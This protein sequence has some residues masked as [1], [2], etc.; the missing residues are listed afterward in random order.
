VA[1]TPPYAPSLTDDPARVERAIAAS[2]LFLATAGL[3]A[4]RLDP[5]SPAGEATIAYAIFVVYLGFAVLCLSALRGRTH[6]AWLFGFV[7]HIVDLAVAGAATLATEGAQTPFLVFLFFPLVTAAYRWGMLETLGTAAASIA[8]LAAEGM[9]V[10]RGGTRGFP[11]VELTAAGLILRASYLALLGFLIGYLADADKRHR[12]EVLCVSRMLRDARVGA[13]LDSV[14]PQVMRSALRFFGARQA[15]LVMQETRTHRTFLRHFEAGTAATGA[16]ESGVQEIAL[17][18]RGDYLF[19]LAG[20]AC[21]GVTSWFHRRHVFFFVGTDARNER[22]ATTRIDV[23]AGFVAMHRCRRMVVID[24]LFDNEWRARAFIL[25]P[26]FAF[27]RD[28]LVRSAK[29]IADQVAPALYDRYMVQRLRSRAMSAE[30]AR[31]VRELHDGPVQSLLG[32]EMQLAVL[33]RRAAALAPELVS[34]LAR[35]HDVLKNEVINLREVFE[36]IRAGI[37]G[38]GPVQD[39]IADLVARFGVY[40]GAAAHFRSDDGPTLVTPRL[41]REILRIVSEALS[42]VRKHSG[43]RRVTVRSMVRER[44]MFV[45][46]E[47]NGRGFAFAGVRTSADLQAAGSGPRTILERLRAIGGEMIIDSKPGVGSRVEF[48]VPLDEASAI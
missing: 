10:A 7:T 39:G 1:P 3:V 40:T 21:H 29:R 34:D 37:D 26:Q 5:P 33:R 36:G 41:R 20:V 25:N 9:L 32:V 18:R 31:I 47:D 15:L 8:F 35:F 38:E 4:I 30:R 2:R 43:A 14:M 46:I 23:P 17:D 19:D 42:N 28:E 6:G 22:V 12:R 11:H 13:R 27:D 44:R 45:S 16:S 24:Q 48:A